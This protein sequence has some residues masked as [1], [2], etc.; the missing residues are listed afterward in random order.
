M[1]TDSPAQQVLSGLF[2]TG[3]GTGIGLMF[4]IIGIAGMLISFTRLRKPVYRV[5]D[6][7]ET[8]PLQT[9]LNGRNKNEQS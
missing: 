1:M 3:K 9:K 2:G 5:L 7:V 4:F 8:E 6:R